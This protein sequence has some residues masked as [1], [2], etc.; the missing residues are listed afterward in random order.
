MRHSPSF[1]STPPASTLPAPARLPL[2]DA[3]RGV[4]LLAMFAY[5][6]AFDLVA[7]GV[8]QQD[9]YHSP[10]WIAARSAILGTFLTVTGISLRLAT[11]TG[12]RWKVLLRR[13]GRIGGCALL[14]SA[15]SYAMFPQSWIWFGVLHHIAVASLLGVAFLRLGS[16]NLVIGAACVGVGA[17]AGLPQFDHPALQWIGLMTHKPVTED[18]V[19]LLPWFG[20]V[21]WGIF[22]GGRIAA[23]GAGNAY[24]QPA[25][26]AGRMLCLA[27]RHSLLLYMIHQ[28]IF[29]GALMLVLRRGV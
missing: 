11:R 9:P 21:L 24:R 28:P 25:T 17:L 6:L 14:A 5:H 20:F 7:F 22:A 3:I 18:Y 13:A 27:G 29:I 10:L 12:V 2:L 23:S 1:A 16:L 15:G 4:A 19:P 26:A 8:L